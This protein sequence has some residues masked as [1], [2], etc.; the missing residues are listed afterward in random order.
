VP[1]IWRLQLASFRLNER[2][3]IEDLRQADLPEKLNEYGRIY[4][5]AIDENSELVLTLSHTTNRKGSDNDWNT[6]L[7]RLRLSWPSHGPLQVAS[8]TTVEPP[9]DR[10]PVALVTVY[11][12]WETK[13]S[14]YAYLQEWV[15]KE[16]KLYVFDWSDGPRPQPRY[17]I[18]LPPYTSARIYRGKLQ[19]VSD[20]VSSNGLNFR[21]PG[22]P[23]DPDHPELL[24]DRRNWARDPGAL[25]PSGLFLDDPDERCATS[26]GDLWCVSQPSGLRIIRHPRRQ[27]WDLIGE[28]R[29]SPLALWFRRYGDHQP[30]FL[31]DSLVLENGYS[32]LALYDVSN[33]AQ[34][35]RV[36]FFQEYNGEVYPTPHFLL[37]MEG[38][39]LTVLDRPK[40]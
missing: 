30:R 32:Q 33:P 10:F 5:F 12:D 1:T 13:V 37:L 22:R 6:D 26:R 25:P 36:G 29:A 16:H 35:R 34:L 18:Q 23:L 40:I 7:L 38:N 15:S 8:R 2:G 31:D 39:L 14:R 20:N 4:G 24:L 11:N 28:Y 17:E 9:P 27:E 19:I 3:Q 21:T